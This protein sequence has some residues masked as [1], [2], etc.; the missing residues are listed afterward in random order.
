MKRT[1]K[2][3]TTPHTIEEQIAIAKEQF[4]R[5]DNTPMLLQPPPTRTFVKGEQ[6]NIGNLKEVFID[7]VLD[8]GMA[9]LYHC[10]WHERDKP[11]TIQY[12]VAWWFDIRKLTSTPNVPRLMSEFRQHP[13]IN[14]G[15]D[16]IIHYLVSGGIVCDPRYQREYVWTEQ[17]K[18]ALLESIFDRLDIGSFLF[19]SHSGYLHANDTTARLYKT[20]D[21]REVSIPRR[22]DYTT[23]IIDGQQRL[24][25]ILDFVLDRRPYKGLWFSDLN[26]RDRY[27]FEQT[28]VMF[29]IV[30]E[31]N[32]TEKDVVRM[33]LQNNRGV[34]QAPE[35]L[36]KVQ[37][38]YESMKS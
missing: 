9:Y 21:G 7:E 6:V 30:N 36:A 22:D 31:E 2:Q 4:Y 23:A 3:S 28:S 17:N 27:E 37:A 10:T 15:L 1:S 19:V 35:H 33:F 13:A 38:L 34:P 25:T 14:S 32:V 12:R 20:I 8:N 26:P 29:R 24:T 11:T 18:D 5:W 16:S